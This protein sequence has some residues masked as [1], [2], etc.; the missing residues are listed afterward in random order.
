MQKCEHMLIATLSLTMRNTSLDYTHY[1]QHCH[2]AMS[3]PRLHGTTQPQKSE[4]WPPRTER[5]LAICI[6]NVLTTILQK[7]VVANYA[8]V[9]QKMFINFSGKFFYIKYYLQDQTVCKDVHHS[10]FRMRIFCEINR[11]SCRHLQ[12]YSNKDNFQIYGI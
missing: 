10:L 1:A 11:H 8:T 5:I 3:V 6:S 7:D 9:N 12:K 4:T 2:A